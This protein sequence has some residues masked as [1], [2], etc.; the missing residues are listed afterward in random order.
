MSSGIANPAQRRRRRWISYALVASVLMTSAVWLVSGAISLQ[1]AYV[2][3][4]QPH[5]TLIV[6][7]IRQGCLTYFVC[8]SPI[9]FDLGITFGFRPPQ[10]SLWPKLDQ[11]PMSHGLGMREHRLPLWVLPAALGLITV[12][13]ATR[14]VA[15][16]RG[17][18]K[19]S[20]C[21]SCGYDLSAARSA[22]C[23]ECGEATSTAS[24]GR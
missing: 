17:R 22:R 23:P 19:S 12:T 11:Q 21:E 15:Q 3:S 1:Y 20:S 10:Y 6:I 16:R 9:I 14:L 4:G 24:Q 18:A 5:L 2:Q 8:E 13:R 7:S